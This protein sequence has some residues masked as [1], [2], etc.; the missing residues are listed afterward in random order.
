M[1]AIGVFYHLGEVIQYICTFIKNIYSRCCI[2][3]WSESASKSLL[4]KRSG[5][6]GD[7]YDA[8]TMPS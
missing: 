6:I 3:I 4:Q 5:E 8:E 7:R 1:Y 2:N